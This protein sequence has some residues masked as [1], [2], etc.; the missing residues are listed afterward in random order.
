MKYAIKDKDKVLEWLIDQCEQSD[1]E[2]LDHVG[3]IKK[4][5]PD[6]PEPAS[7]QAG[8]MKL[9]YI[10]GPYRADTPW[11][12]EQNIREAEI[13]AL[14]VAEIGLVPVIPHSMYRYF[15]ESLSDDY[16]LRA[17]IDI[18][19]RCDAV[20]AFR[21]WM[22]SKGTDCEIATAKDLDIPVLTS[23]EHVRDYANEHGL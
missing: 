3:A 23:L 12:V 8:R 1:L 18:M 2:Q 7:G 19:T 11:E 16:F 22:P 9:I 20:Y 21:K 4:V 5:E 10:A 15:N 14:C 17:T 13:A 6:Q